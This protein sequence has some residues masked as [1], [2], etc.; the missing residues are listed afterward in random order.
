MATPY[1]INIPMYAGPL[2]LLLDLIKQQKMNIHDI[3][4]SKI[5]AQ[6]LEYLHKLEELDV[7][8]SAEFIYMAATLIYIK[9]KMLLPPDP[10]AGPEDAA[11]D[12]RA[13]LVQRLVE[14]EKFKNAAQLLYQK[15]QIEENVWSKPDKSL[16]H[17][18]GTAGELVVSLVDL[19]RV[20]QQVLERRKEVSR[21]E[22]RH[23]EFT[24]A[25][26][27]AALRTQILASADNSV[28]LIQFFEACPS[29][30]AMIVAFLAV[31]EMVKLQAV[32][33]VQEKQFGDILVR[34]HKMFD[35][36][37]DEAG[38]IKLIDEE[39]K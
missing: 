6:Y 34:K 7:D 30:H 13:E 19:V 22:L 31:L 20:F 28:N 29:R 39:Y 17:D 36:V 8:V 14:H 5:T 16:Y 37:F 38:G 15:Q 9:S 21:I 26:M 3:Q 32:E 11:G 24:V 33:L 2:D 25:Q 18:E 12:P 4:I 10:L 35:L 27:I 1:K 23:E